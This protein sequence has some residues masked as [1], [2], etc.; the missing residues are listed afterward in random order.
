MLSGRPPFGTGEPHAVLMRTLREKPVPISELRESIPAHVGTAV[1]RLLEKKPA[2][3][4][5]DAAQVI[6]ALT[7]PVTGST[8]REQR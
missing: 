2:D 3:R 5:S 6:D 4:Y 1:D 8:N 7:A